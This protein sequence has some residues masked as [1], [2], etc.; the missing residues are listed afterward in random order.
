MSFLLDKCTLKLLDEKVLSES[1]EFKCKNTDKKS[2]RDLNEFFK[3][4][5]CAFTSQLLGKTYCFTLDSDPSTIICAFTLSN[6][7]IKANDL[8]NSRKRK[9][10]KYIPNQKHFKSYP[11]VLIGRLG[12][13]VD[14][15]RNGIGSELMTFIKSWFRDPLN[16]TGCRFIAVD[17]YNIEEVK[18]YYLKNGLWF[19]FSSEEQE[20]DYLGLPNILEDGSKPEPLKTRLMVYDLIHLN[21]GI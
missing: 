6:E 15:G 12:V 19:L 8:P 13:S 20:R 17:S 16:K 7:S 9:L 18:E 14:Y 5:C 11:A 1:K 2:T 10:T 4:D 21:P 3:K